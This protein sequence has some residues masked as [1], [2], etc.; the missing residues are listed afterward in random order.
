MRVPR[1]GMIVE[2]TRGRLARVSCGSEALA[3]QRHDAG[4]DRQHRGRDGGDDGDGCAGLAQCAA[5]DDGDDAAGL[6]LERGAGVVEHRQRVVDVEL[7]GVGVADDGLGMRQGGLERLPRLGRV[8]RPVQLLGSIA[9]IFLSS[10][11]L[12]TGAGSGVFSVSPA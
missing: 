9:L 8:L 1:P 7:R 4:T 10:S 5:I 11:D 12:L 2:G 6:L 3:A